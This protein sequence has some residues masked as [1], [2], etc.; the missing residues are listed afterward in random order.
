MRAGKKR[1][2]AHHHDAAAGTPSGGASGGRPLRCH[3]RCCVGRAVVAI[4]PALAVRVGS[5][6][7]IFLSFFLFRLWWSCWPTAP[8]PA[9][10]AVAAA[11]ASRHAAAHAL[12]D[13]AGIEAGLAT[14]TAVSTWPAPHEAAV[15]DAVLAAALV[16]GADGLPAWLAA[17]ADGRG[18]APAADEAD[19]MRL[20][21]TRVAGV[22]VGG[23]QEA[24]P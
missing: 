8:I 18:G 17:E 12:T 2:G 1:R 10:A 23:S 4:T 16:A 24:A 14:V 11:A 19:A 9:A 6:R 3:R 13:V 22:H 20:E 15:G 21:V 7:G 5:T